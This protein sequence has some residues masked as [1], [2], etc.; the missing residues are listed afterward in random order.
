VLL[1]LNLGMDGFN[2][3][4]LTNR[5]DLDGQWQLVRTWN[6]T[7]W[8]YLPRV[9][10][11]PIPYYTYGIL[12]RFIAKH[13]RILAIE[14]GNNQILASALLSPDG[15]MTVIVLN[16]SANKEELTLRLPMNTGKSDF[17]KYQVT[18]ALVKSPGYQMSPVASFNISAAQP[19]ITD[20]LPP[21]SITVYSNYHL[22]SNDPGIISE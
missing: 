22:S 8:N 15:N 2:R 20:T 7:R 9:T 5:G 4:S 11:E 1:G 14:L 17:H 21:A 10:P 3:W 19:A 12:T 6:P 13:S 16:K 18:E